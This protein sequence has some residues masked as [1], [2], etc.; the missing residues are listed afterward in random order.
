MKDANA[1]GEIPFD[2]SERLTARL[3]DLV[4][5]YPKGPGLVKEFLQNADDAGA[6]KLLVVLDRRTHDAGALPPNL[7]AAQGPALLFFN[8]RVFSEDDF[9]RIQQVGAGGK[10]E[11]AAGTGRFGH[12][13]NTCYSVS[14]HP[15]LLTGERVAWFDPH[16]NAACRDSPQ[17]ARA[18]LINSKAGRELLPWLKTFSACGWDESGGTFDGTTFRL[19]LRSAESAPL[20]EIS[21]EPFVDNDFEEI[22]EK[23]REIGAPLLLFLRSVLELEVRE[24][25]PSGRNI[26]R[27]SVKT[28]NTEDVESA[29]APLRSFVSG[30]PGELLGYCM[31]SASPLPVA[32]FDHRVSVSEGADVGRE[33]TWAVVTGLFSG[34]D[35]ALL[36]AAIRVTEVGEKAI[37]WAGAATRISSGDSAPNAGLACFLPLLGSIHWPVWIHGWFDLPSNR[38]G[39]T[40]SREA[41]ISNHA[42]YDWNELL[43]RHAAGCAWALLL[44]KI[45][46]DAKYHSKPYRLWPGN[47]SDLDGIDAALVNGFYHYVSE[48]PV[49]RAR[50]RES[51]T[52]C[53]VD[54]GACTLDVGWHDKLIEAFSTEGWRVCDPPVPPH[55]VDGFAAAG[56][57]IPQLTPGAV[58]AHLSKASASIE[59]PSKLGDAAPLPMLRTRGWVVSIAEFC[60]EEH[61]TNLVGLPL[62][63]RVDQQLDRFGKEKR[64]YLVPNHAAVLLERPP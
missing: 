58:R 25:D 17:N 32:A 43:M 49:L 7:R 20:S 61:P 13:F 53:K 23:L 62:A 38:Q 55:V 4:R 33:E 56:R 42:R 18:W 57:P 64:F 26:S 16:H 54:D 2:Q 5:H 63:L 27:F 29:R 47:H 10:V 6:R 8:D 52:W 1:E 21:K 45:A 51:W 15:S 3:R 48:L 11:E 22:I 30:R 41:G 60:S 28:V 46:G 59:L 44:K 9:K 34:P 31:E 39:I 36:K 12:G 37:P 14:D 50:L 40:R 19:P 35:K 24:V